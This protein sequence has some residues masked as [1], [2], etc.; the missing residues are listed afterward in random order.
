MSRLIQ[1][2]N[3]QK[4]IMKIH[5]RRLFFALA[6]LAGIY[7]VNAAL[8]FA[9]VSLQHNGLL[10]WTTPPGTYAS[11]LEW[12]PSLT[13]PAWVYAA[14]P[15]DLIISA[16]N[17]NTNSV[18]ILPPVGFYRLAQGLPIWHGVWIETNGSGFYIMPNGEGLITNTGTYNVLAP[19]GTYAVTN[20]NVSLTINTTN[21][22]F[23]E[24]GQFVAPGDVTFNGLGTFLPATNLS[25]CAGNWSGTLIETNDPNGLEDYSIDLDVNTNGFATVSGDFSGTGRM[26]AL[27]S[28]NGIFSSF[29]RTTS[30]G[31]Y[32]QFR[33]IGILNGNTIT[34]SYGTDSGSGANAVTGTVTLTR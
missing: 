12:T 27:S 28:A 26:F 13:S 2:V 34:A 20:A 5:I 9:I 31:D 7:Q 33:I 10:V 3:N 22:T 4:E 17:R 16:N 25:L 30:T 24:S 32:D 14:P 21:Q 29:F 15:L 8:P 1:A 19:P 23:N 11:T 18:P 6:T